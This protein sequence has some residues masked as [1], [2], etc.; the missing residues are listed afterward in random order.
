MRAGSSSWMRAAERPQGH[1]ARPLD[2]ADRP[3][4]RLADVDDLE[5]LSRVEAALQ[6]GGADLLHGRAV[7]AP[8]SPAEG[9]VVLQLDD[10]GFRR[11]EGALGIAREA[12]LVEAHGEGVVEEQAAHERLPDPQ[13]DLE[14]LGGLYAPDDAGED[15]EDTALRAARNETGRRRLREE[16][17]VAGPA[18]SPEHARLPLEAEDGAV[19]VGLLQ[20][21]ARVVGEVAGLEVVGAVDHHVVAA[22]EE[23]ALSRVRATAWASTRDVRVEG[24][25]RATALSSLGRPTQPVSWRIWRWRLLSSTTSKS[26]MPIRPTPAA[27]R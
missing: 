20:E 26:T 14:G 17:A 10:R 21:V 2:P 24:E 7:P 23:R 25:R 11:A 5:R 6:L 8:P 13:E 27:A 22:Q 19:D 4:V 12:H 1:E 3:L 15:A 16:A 18:V 9:R